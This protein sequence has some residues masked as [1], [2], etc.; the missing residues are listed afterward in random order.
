MKKVHSRLP[1]N[2]ELENLTVSLKGKFIFSAIKGIVPESSL[3]V[4]EHFHL[5]YDIPYE[6]IGVITG[7]CH[8]EEVAEQKL[9]Y[10]T[11]SGID[12][13]VTH[14]LA[15]HFATNYINT[16]VNLDIYGVQFI[17][18]ACFVCWLISY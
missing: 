1:S 17:F 12:E 2:K 6:N 16:I 15:A 10:L 14:Q 4:G 9:S 18:Y 8:A 5:K 11:F 3:I 7:P 13:A